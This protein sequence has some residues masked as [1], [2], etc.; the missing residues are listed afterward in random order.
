[1]TFSPI[2]SNPIPLLPTGAAQPHTNPS[3]CSKTAAPCAL[4]PLSPLSPLPHKIHPLSQAVLHSPPSNLLHH[5]THKNSTAS[6][7]SHTNFLPPQSPP[8]SN[9]TPPLEFTFQASPQCP[10][11]KAYST[12]ANPA[13]FTA[14]FTHLPLPPTNHLPQKPHPKS[15]SFSTPPVTLPIQALKC[16]PSYLHQPSPTFPPFFPPFKDLLSHLCSQ[17]PM[18]S[19]IIALP[20]I[21]S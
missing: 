17:L 6:C 11:T 9:Q 21:T 10:V 14:A 15:T 3:D 1:M 13:A 20:P 2:A 8:P 5:V 12:I 16:S 7:T 18:I 19:S 4:S